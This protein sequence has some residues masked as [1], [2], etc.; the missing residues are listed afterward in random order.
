VRVGRP[1][2]L[3][4]PARPLRALPAP[5]PGPQHPVCPYCGRRHARLPRF[6]LGYGTG[7]T[8]RPE[9]PEPLG[10]S[11]RVDDKAIRRDMFHPW[12]E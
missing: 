6:P 9:R 3:P 10:H 2:P 11:S 7:I 4:P 12:R 8:P 5:P 1:E